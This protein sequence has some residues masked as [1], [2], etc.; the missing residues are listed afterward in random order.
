MLDDAVEALRLL[1]RAASAGT[2]P[3]NVYFALGELHYHWG[4][5]LEFG[6]RAELGAEVGFLSCAPAKIL[7]R[8]LPE[9]SRI[10]TAST[11]CAETKD[12]VVGAARKRTPIGDWAREQES[13]P[14]N[15]AHPEIGGLT[16]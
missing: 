15:P 6:K 10:P 3:Q 5:L 4:E 8:T 11:C 16:T 1:L 7:W 13:E 12:D 2:V 14:P 9:R